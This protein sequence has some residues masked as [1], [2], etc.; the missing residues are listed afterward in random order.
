M[1]DIVMSGPGC[2]CHSSHALESAADESN[3]ISS[4]GSSVV[5]SGG[6]AEDRLHEAAHGLHRF[7]EFVI[8]SASTLEWR[9][10]SRCVC[11]DR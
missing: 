4:R 8:G 6:H 7:T 9:A 10:I 5:G 1:A 2:T 11:R 3:F